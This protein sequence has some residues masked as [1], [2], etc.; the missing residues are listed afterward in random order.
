MRNRCLILALVLGLGFGFVGLARPAA[1]ANNDDAEKINK[2]VE[3]LGSSKFADRDK[4]KRELESLGMKALEALRKAAKHGDLETSRRASEILKKL[5]DKIATDA[6]L[7]P[8]KV[9]LNF[10]DTPVLEAVAELSRQSGYPIDVQGDRTGINKRTITLTTGEV[11]FWEAFDQLCQ[12]AGLV[13]LNAFSNLDQPILWPQ[14]VPN[15]MPIKIRPIKIQPN[16]QPLPIRPG[17]PGQ[18]PGGILPVVPPAPNNNLPG[19]LDA[20]KRALENVPAKPMI[21]PLL[22]QVEVQGVPIQIELPIQVQ[23]APGAPGAAGGAGQAQPAQVQPAQ[24]QPLP[25]QIQPLP[26]GRRPAPVQIPPG[27]IVVKDGKPSEVPACYSG[28]VRIRLLPADQPRQI[29][30]QPAKAG[31]VLL[32]LEVTSEPRLQNFMVLGARA[33]K[34]IDDQGQALTMAMEPMPNNPNDPAGF[35]GIAAPAFRVYPYGMQR[36]VALRIKL[37]DKQAK[38]LKEL[39]GTIS[40]QTLSAP[41]ALI[42][43]DDV[44]KAAGKTAKGKN[45]GAIELLNIEKKGDDTYQIKIR[46]ENPPNT[47]PLGGNGIIQFMP[48]NGIQ[49]QQIQING[50]GIA[51]GRPGSTVNN[52]GLPTLVDEKGQ[53][54][55]LTQIPARS[56]RGVN[57]VFSQEVTMVFQANP[58]QG[59]PARLVLNGHRMLEV[60]VPFAL[61][62]VPLP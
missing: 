42:S 56:Y 38:S 24:I 12:K 32:I 54:Y 48:A 61:K 31:E 4:A 15:P 55:K 3:Q 20:L 51:V 41:E 49:M 2:L 11:T 5:E 40:A 50:G 47:N 26:G 10:K 14:P 13:E 28:A 19:V 57:G 46:L 8:K 52:N 22:L 1:S 27:T 39:T 7:A 21:A 30:V 44:L 25:A 9:K 16:V 6:I 37:G 53:S 36:Q 18:L 34:M 59:A 23:G 62:N 35:G 33:E 60:Q 58:G 29:A 43:V 17:Q 45:G